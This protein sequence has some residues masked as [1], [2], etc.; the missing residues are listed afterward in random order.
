MEDAGVIPLPLSMV[1]MVVHRELSQ[2]VLF[3][4]PHMPAA[5]HTTHTSQTTLAGSLSTSLLT[6]NAHKA[7][8]LVQ[9]FRTVS[10]YSEYSLG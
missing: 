2:L 6:R 4:D 7:I 9:Q 8:T 3:G 10:Q 1:P 5:G